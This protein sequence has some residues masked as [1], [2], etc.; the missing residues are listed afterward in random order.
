[1]LSKLLSCRKV[2]SQSLKAAESPAPS[3][4]PSHG[5]SASFHSLLPLQGSSQ[6]E[7]SVSGSQ[8]TSSIYAREALI[9]IDYGD[10]C[11]DLK[12]RIGLWGVGD[13]FPAVQR[14][15]QLIWGPL[16]TRTR[17][18]GKLA[19]EVGL[20]YDPGSPCVHTETAAHP[21]PPQVVP[22]PAGCLSSPSR[23]VHVSAPIQNRLLN[24]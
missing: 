14:E 9:E 5:Q 8:R 16:E 12:V 24:R 23:H 20:S 21:P 10:L 2:L 15:G 17:K 7:D 4:G 6:G 22:I 13:I 3:R 11:E 1:M 19:R 18:K